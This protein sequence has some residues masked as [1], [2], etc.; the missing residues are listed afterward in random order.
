MSENTNT[1]TDALTA[2]NND[3][4]KV[5][6]WTADSED[7]ENRYKAIEKNHGMARCDK[8]VYRHMNDEQ[9]EAVYNDAKAGNWPNTLI[10]L[11]KLGCADNQV[12]KIFE[13]HEFEPINVRSTDQSLKVRLERAKAKLENAQADFDKLLIE[14]SEERQK[15]RSE[16]QAQLAELEEQDNLAAAVE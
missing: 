16:L 5:V 8:G 13:R 14:S 1:P 2:N 15:L 10:A 4:A 12:N 3:S 6:L 11:C 9:I 7:M